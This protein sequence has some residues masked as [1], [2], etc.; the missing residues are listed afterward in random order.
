[1]RA[2]DRGYVGAISGANSTDGRSA[3]KPRGAGARAGLN[4]P[5]AADAAAV[6]TRSDACERGRR[7]VRGV[8]GARVALLTGGGVVWLARRLLANGAQKPQETHHA[9]GLKLPLLKFHS[10]HLLP[11]SSTELWCGGVGVQQRDW[12]AGTHRRSS[13]AS[14]PVASDAQLTTPNESK[15]VCSGRVAPP[16]CRERAW[17][18]YGASPESVHGAGC[19]RGAI[20]GR[21]RSRLAAKSPPDDIISNRSVSTQIT[22][23]CT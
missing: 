18:M 23:T 22:N 8:R 5:P 2:L 15:L 13:W 20:E 1:V 14:R 19:A 21:G 7:W 6:H 3:R 16:T 17:Y 11:R 4:W 10:R 12:C 9:R